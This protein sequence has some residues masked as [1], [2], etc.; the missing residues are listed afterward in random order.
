MLSASDQ[1]ESIAMCS[2]CRPDMVV[3]AYPFGEPGYC[4]LPAILSRLQAEGRVYLS[5]AV[6]GTRFALR[7]C[8]VNFRTTSADV[9]AVVDASVTAGRALDKEMRPAYAAPD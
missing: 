7:A 6:V 9:Q 4:P 8:I 2:Q 5:N 3:V 1:D